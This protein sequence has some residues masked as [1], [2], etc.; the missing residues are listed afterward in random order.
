M[1]T[2]LIASLA[3]FWAWETVLVL[4]PWTIPPW[5]Q[6]FIVLAA[7]L[8][9]CWPDWRVAGAA[10]GAVGLLHVAVRGVIEPVAP[11]QAVRVRPGVGQRVPDLP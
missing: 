6:P 10:A 8:A 9:F 3:V 4:V 11:A 1:L 5:L 7:S 2:L